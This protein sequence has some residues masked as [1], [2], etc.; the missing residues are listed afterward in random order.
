[1]HPDGVVMVE[2]TTRRPQR[3]DEGSTLI[4]VLVL[5]LVAGFIVL[6]LMSY[7]ISVRRASQVE[8]DKARSV[9]MARGGFWVA[10][11]YQGDLYDQCGAEPIP[12]SLAGVTTTCEVLRTA[13]LR[14]PEEV[15]FEIAVVQGDTDGMGMR[16]EIPA[17]LTGGT[18]YPNPNSSADPAAWLATPDW[19][20]DSQVGKVWLPQLP[21]RTTS[22]GGTRDTTMPP[23]T[24]DPNYSSCQVF[25]PGT[26]TTEI[27][28]DGPAY[29]TS[30]VYYFTEPLVL[31]G[32]AD[33][34][35]GNGSE[36]GCTTDFEAVASAASVPDPLN[37]TG[38]GGTFVF[39]ENASLSID[40]GGGDVRFAMNKRY[41]SD[42]EASVLVSSDVAII[43][44]NG[45]HAPF[46]SAD[47]ADVLEADLA[48]PAVIEVPR[49]SVDDPDDDPDTPGDDPWATDSGYMPSVLTPKPKEP[50]APTNVV[51][52]DYRR[53]SSPAPRGRL[54]VTWDAP[55]NNGALIT[56][57]VATASSGGH[58]CSPPT[59]PDANS[60]GLPDWPLQPSCTMTISSQ[61]DFS[62][63]VV[64]TNAYGDSPSSAGSNTVRVDYMGGGQSPLLEEPD[65]P[66]SVAVGTGYSDGLE[67]TWNPPGDDGGSPITG[68]RV[69]ATP[70]S[71]VGDTSDDVECTAWWDENSCVLPLIDQPAV[72]DQYVV[73]VVATSSVGDSSVA[74]LD[75]DLLDAT[76]P[77]PDPIVYVAGGSPSVP[78][79]VDVAPIRVPDP[80][81]DLSFESGNHDVD[82]VIAGFVVV[83]Q[84]HVLIDAP[85]PQNKSV[86]LLGGLTAAN[87]RLMNEPATLEVVFSNPVAQKVVRI[88]STSGDSYGAVADAVVQVNRSGSVAV[89]SLVVQ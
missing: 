23:G 2:R 48:V 8:I 9:Q 62:A 47:P 81:V 6:P 16:A 85:T 63:S 21:T 79:P 45:N 68:Y 89:N 36:I 88:R 56:Q 59:P 12:S 42:T 60:D 77:E 35:V 14:P 80:I 26:F 37:I 64:A 41:V 52:D 69:T 66:T 73:A 72:D 53:G 31:E 50:D 74:S 44:V 43:S 3:R 27:T 67:I 57:Y 34:V 71:T 54:T 29:F 33:V 65:P 13:T 24:Q 20:F 10:L 7:A 51:V 84:G 28:I 5:I 76:P 46:A 75:G 22:G 19:S 70:P 15:P 25:F 38:L 39:G 18:N 86:R 1:M 11:S 58:T 87:L 61:G 40:D 83:P 55:N 78:R 49:S 82:I 17:S 32:D 4:L 30:G